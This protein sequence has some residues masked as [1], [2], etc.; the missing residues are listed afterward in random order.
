VS[1]GAAGNDPLHAAETVASGPEDFEST[2]QVVPWH[3]SE[4]AGDGRRLKVLRS[5][6]RCPLERVDGHEAADG[7]TITLHERQPPAF[8]RDGTSVG[9]PMDGYMRCVEVPLSAPLGNRTVYDGAT[10]EQP[11][12]I[13]PGDSMERL[14][15]ADALDVDLDTFPCQPM[16]SREPIPQ[17]RS[18]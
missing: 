3:R 11:A 5:T 14:G 10:G 16:P 9:I 7:V 18:S 8:D 13:V 17:D 1:L 2:L 6:G 15:R 12:D 4:P